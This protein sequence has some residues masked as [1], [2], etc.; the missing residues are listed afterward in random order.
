MIWQKRHVECGMHMRHDWRSWFDT[1]GAVDFNGASGAARSVNSARQADVVESVTKISACSASSSTRRQ[2]S[3][4]TLCL[5]HD[6]M[7]GARQM[8]TR[9]TSRN[10]ISNPRSM[11]AVIDDVHHRRAANAAVPA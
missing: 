5:E 7:D 6:L 11:K 9:W 3:G 4:Q 2:Q 1:S 8:E 10:I